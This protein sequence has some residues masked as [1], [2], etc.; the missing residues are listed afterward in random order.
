MEN[1]PESNSGKSE[2]IEGGII[3][4]LSAQ[5]LRAKVIE[6]QKMK[7]SLEVTPLAGGEFL[8]EYVLFKQASNEKAKAVE[9]RNSSIELI[10][11]TPNVAAGIAASMEAFSKAD[12]NKQLTWK[13]KTEMP[14]LVALV[15][16]TRA[17]EA[18][19]FTPDPKIIV[20]EGSKLRGQ[21][22]MSLDARTEGDLRLKHDG[23]TEDR[24]ILRPEAGKQKGGAE[25]GPVDFVAYDKKDFATIGQEYQNSV[26]NPTGAPS[27]KD[28]LSADKID[29]NLDISKATIDAQKAEA[30]AVIARLEARNTAKKQVEVNGRPLGSEV[31]INNFSAEEQ[32]KKKAEWL[33][34]HPQGDDLDIDLT[35]MEQNALQRP[36]AKLEGANPDSR[37]ILKPVN[38][39]EGMPE[40]EKKNLEKVFVTAVADKA[41]ETMKEITNVLNQQ[42]NASQKNLE[43][44][45][46]NWLSKSLEALKKAPPAYR[47]ALGVT[48]AGASVATGGLTAILGVGVSSLSYGSVVYEKMLKLKQEGGHEINKASIAT[49]ALTSGIVLALATGWIAGEVFSHVDVPEALDGIKGTVKGWWDSLV[50]T[51]PEVVVPSTDFSK[52]PINGL[53]MDNGLSVN[54]APASG[55]FSSAQA[56]SVASQPYAPINPAEFDVADVPAQE[57]GESV[58]GSYEGPVT[59][60]VPEPVAAPEA[61]PLPPASPPKI[62]ENVLRD[63][64]G[65][66]VTDSSGNPIKTGDVEINRY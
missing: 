55:V 58:S 45:G 62:P 9:L 56:P 51:T 38:P 31:T 25:G 66:I 35:K 29:I 40:Q 50:G 1:T 22:E 27:Q 28:E 12:H 54:N 47:I 37:V 57:V 52:M 5:E 63:S 61:A 7:E 13:Q 21:S 39:A 17:L 18:T 36:G 26:G 34:D 20:Q 65:G 44:M 33:R 46:A 43:N 23:T 14:E 11:N 59:A 32:A 4:P 15:K 24:F 10:S 8:D 53:T 2:M 41:P 16:K 64:Y 42:R 48:F 3:L 6:H 49:N 30:D 19:A 60:P